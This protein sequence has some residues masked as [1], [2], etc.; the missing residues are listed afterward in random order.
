MGTT[1]RLASAGS[2][3]LLTPWRLRAKALSWLL[4]S[5]CWRKLRGHGPTEHHLVLVNRA[6]LFL[7]LRNHFSRRAAQAAPPLQAVLD[8]SPEAAVDALASFVQLE[9]SVRAAG[10]AARTCTL[11]QNGVG[12]L[13]P[14]HSRPLS[15]LAHRTWADLSGCVLHRRLAFIR[16]PEAGTWSE[17]PS[18]PPF[19]GRM[20]LWQLRRCAVPDQRRELSGS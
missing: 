10:A 13:L 18:T 4:P 7:R 17:S 3:G 6:D 20:S 15:F 12:F 9:T 16:R 14:A 8:D 2:T 1:L 19:L 5:S 11:W